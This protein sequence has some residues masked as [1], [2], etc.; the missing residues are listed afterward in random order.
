MGQ[1]YSSIRPPAPFLT[2]ANLQDQTGKVFVVTGASG[3]VGK[4]LASILYQH[5]AKVYIAARSEKKSKEAISDIQARYPSSNGCLEYLR[6]D[7][8]DL[9]G[10]KDAAEE[11][12]RKET[13]LDVLWNNAG[14]MVPPRGSKTIQGYELQFGVNNMGPFLFTRLLYPLLKAT[15]DMAPEHSVRIIWVSSSAV[16]IAPSPA[17]DLSAMENDHEDS[18]I[19]YARSKSGNI[20]HAVEFARRHDTDAIINLSLN[21]GNLIT[22]LQ[23]TLPGWQK[24]LWKKIAYEPKF[25]AYTELYAGL[26]T[27]ISPANNGGWVAPFGRLMQCRQ[28]LLDPELGKRFWEWSENQISPY[29]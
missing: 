28:D 12:L 17:I 22:D 24:Y 25:G 11:I 13:R 14:V 15:S 27:D 7:L 3:G 4:C 6:L 23:R 5:N 16:D 26:S 21:P 29:L 9:D 19:R 1:I 20:L 2:E 8:A 10:V 18:W